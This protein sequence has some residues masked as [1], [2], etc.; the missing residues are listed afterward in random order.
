M[1]EMQGRGDEARIREILGFK[2][3]GSFVCRKIA[4]LMGVCDM[5]HS[6]YN[7]VKDEKYFERCTDTGKLKGARPGFVAKVLMEL[8]LLERTIE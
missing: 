1:A 3:S 7:M 8:D 4:W 6:A 2:M 5:P